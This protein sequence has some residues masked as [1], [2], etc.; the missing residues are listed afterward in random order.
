MN[1]LSTY[2]WPGNVRELENVIENALII[3]NGEVLGVEVPGNLGLATK[4]ES[5]LEDLEREHIIKVLE[6]VNWQVGGKDGAAERLGLKRT[7]LN[8]KMKKHK[9]KKR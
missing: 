1:N 9:I 2:S 8:S 4:G 3:S 5:K 6:S 7:T